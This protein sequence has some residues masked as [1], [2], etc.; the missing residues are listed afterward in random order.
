MATQDKLLAG[1]NRLRDKAGTT[2]TVRYFA[3]TIGSIY[4]DDYSLAQSGN[5]LLF[6]GI[7]FPL[8]PKSSE[9][10]VLLEQ[11]K[12]NHQDM[13]LFMPGSILLNMPTGSLYVCDLR[14]GSPAQKYV[15]KEGGGT[16]WEIQ[17]TEIYKKVYISRLIGGS[18]FGA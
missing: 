17:G 15:I 3:Q 9:D 6:S 8:S 4:D 13:K 11:G 5:N 2:V 18:L 16:P 7:V 12:I 1:F 10:M 14:I